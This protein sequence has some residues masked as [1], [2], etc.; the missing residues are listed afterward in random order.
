MHT[1]RVYFDW[2]LY[3]IIASKQLNIDM[4]S[5]EF[6]EKAIEVSI[7]PMIIEEMCQA[8][9]NVIDSTIK[10]IK[11]FK[12]SPVL[13][14]PNEIEV[15]ELL[16]EI[17]RSCPSF[18][19]RDSTFD[20]SIWGKGDS[21]A[22]RDWH[23]LL[24]YGTSFV[25]DAAKQRLIKNKLIN[26]YYQSLLKHSDSLIDTDYHTLSNGDAIEKINK[27]SR[28]W[29]ESE[30]L[31]LEELKNE[32]HKV[33]QRPTLNPM[34][35]EWP[36]YSK[37]EQEHIISE[38]CKSQVISEYLLPIRD[39]EIHKPEKADYFLQALTIDDGDDAQ[40]LLT[41]LCDSIDYKNI[42]SLRISVMV[43]I[44]QLTQEVMASNVFDQM[45]AVYIKE[46]DRFLTCDKNYYGVLSND[47][48]SDYLKSIGGSCKITYLHPDDI[49]KKTIFSKILS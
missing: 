45:Y 20:C 21:Q 8:P 38:F 7:G 36:K 33:N 27:I 28:F 19:L 47:L 6:K 39:R 14:H 44:L 37:T 29:Y 31:S 26:R 13:R 49:S 18:I 9:S 42:P 24:Q 15:N 43:S 17:K 16:T 1:T 22:D 34:I 4:L 40:N 46:L 25:D 23:G 30:R 3:S 10:V 32:I 35:K 12:T 2:N 11:A 48:I 5:Q 41:C